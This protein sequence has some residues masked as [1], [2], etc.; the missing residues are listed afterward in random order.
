MKSRHLIIILFFLPSLLKAQDTTLLTSEDAVRLAIENNLNIK[1]IEADRDIAMINNNW[2]NAGRWPVVNA[3]IGNTEALSNLNQSLANGTEI[4]RNGVTN[5][6]LNANIQASWRI[7][8]GK[9]VVATKNRFEELEKI[10]EINVSQQMQRIS[11]DVLV[12]YNNIVRFNQQVKAFHAIIAL[13]RERYTIAK[14]RFDVGSAAKTDMLQSQ[15]DLNEQEIN[16]NN[17]E[18]QIQD[19][20]AILN[21]LL[22][23]P[24]AYPITVAD[25]TFFI[26]TLN[27][28]SAIAKIDTQNLDLLRAERERAILIEERRIIN[29]NR[30][31]SLSL[32]STTNYNRTKASG[33]FFLTNQTY[34]PNIGLSMAIPI[35]NSN[36]FKTQLRTNEVLQKQQKFQTELIRTQLQRDMFIAFQEFENAKHVADVEEKNVKIATENNFISTERFK[37]LQG[38][39]IELR[40]A[41]LS[42]IE[43]QD[44]YINALYREKLAALSAQLIIGEVGAE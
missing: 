20:K 16:L 22:K 18:R 7:Y 5:N 31:P 13:S 21:T 33:G 15:I 6:T 24:P 14:T 39:S 43:A 9:R 1:I 28:D 25:S 37:K 8:N 17:V 10:G 3:N 38:N 4:K 30:I 29:S 34:G 11:F 44:R 35:Y 32:N 36:V 19:N 2:G 42:L 41:Q 23:R 40:Q 12:V 27:Y 26:P